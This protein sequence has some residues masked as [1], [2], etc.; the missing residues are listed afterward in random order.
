MYIFFLL[1]D[2]GTCIETPF[3]ATDDNL[4][5]EP[6]GFCYPPAR[7]PFFNNIN[8]AVV[9]QIT[10]RRPALLYVNLEAAKDPGPFAI[11]GAA[12]SHLDLRI[13]RTMLLF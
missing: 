1:R 2:V 4:R 8:I 3:L 10:N 6:R 12:K 11:R 13:F 9:Y 5:T 7:S